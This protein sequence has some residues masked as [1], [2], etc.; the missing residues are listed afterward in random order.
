MRLRRHWTTLQLWRATYSSRQGGG[1][2][3]HCGAIVAD[4]TTG[5]YIDSRKV[6]PLIHKRQFFS[7]KGPLNIQCCPQGYP[8]IIQAG[9]SPAGPDLSAR[10]AGSVR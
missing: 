1:V 8:V 4:K 2:S 5:K 10:V 9:G 6:R 7:V 3:E